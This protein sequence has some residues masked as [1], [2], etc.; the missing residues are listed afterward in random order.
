MGDDG[1]GR[2]LERRQPRRWMGWTAMVL[3]FSLTLLLLTNEATAEQQ[4]PEPDDP[5]ENP[6]LAGEAFNQGT[7]LYEAGDLEGALGWFRC[8]YGLVPHSDTLFNIGQVAEELGQLEVALESFDTLLDVWPDYPN[9]AQLERRTARLRA[10]VGGSDSLSDVAPS[11]PAAPQPGEPP[12]SPGPL[13]QGGTSQVGQDE[14][15]A[16]Q[17]ERD[18]GDE[19]EGGTD[20]EPANRRR[21][22]AR[23]V[24][25]ALLG[26]GLSVA[27]SG[28][29]VIGVAASENEDFLAQR[30]D[31][32]E[33]LEN[34]VTASERGLTMERAGWPLLEIGGATL[35]AAILVLALS[36][37]GRRVDPSSATSGQW[38]TTLVHLLS[39]GT[40]PEGRD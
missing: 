26:L 16:D 14:E 24:G 21:R 6:R 11:P 25:W 8:S 33:S 38:A 28:G 32:D 40:E 34:L 27:I 15:L 17:D 10:R 30:S 9:H 12:T 35:V 23:I 31:P 1:V 29:T 18:G 5:A 36:Y 3:A 37:R 22:T 2:P 4:C 20:G 19:V 7:W 39:A 13:A